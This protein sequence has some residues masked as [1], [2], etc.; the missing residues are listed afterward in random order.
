MQ[1]ELEKPVLVF[2]GLSDEDTGDEGVVD[3]DKDPLEDEEDVDDGETAGVS[4]DES[5]AGYGP[6]ADVNS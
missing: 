3:D 6:D 4:G 1:T 5:E 2:R